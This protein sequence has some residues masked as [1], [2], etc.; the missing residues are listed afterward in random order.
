MGPSEGVVPAPYYR[1]KARRL[2]ETNKDRY[3]DLL[4][5]QFAC[6]LNNEARETIRAGRMAEICVVLFRML[7]RAGKLKAETDDE[8]A[9]LAIITD[10]FEFPASAPA[11]NQRIASPFLKGEAYT[12]DVAAVIQASLFGE[13]EAA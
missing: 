13:E 9:L 10:R 6:A 2:V 1:E 4:V 12:Q 5:E 11:G 7:T 3:T 8:R